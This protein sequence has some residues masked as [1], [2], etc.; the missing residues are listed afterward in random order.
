LTWS[1][2][3]LLAWAATQFAPAV[4]VPV[5]GTAAVLAASLVP[6]LTVAAVPVVASAGRQRRWLPLI[7]A[8][9]GGVRLLL[10][11]AYSGRVDPLSVVAAV[12]SQHPDVLVV[13][14]LT[15]TLAHDLTTAGLDRELAARSIQ[16]PQQQTP[17]AADA[18]IGIWSQLPVDGATR[19]PGT[20]W[21]AVT[22]TVHPPGTVPFTLVAGHVAP[23]GTAGAT[24]WNADLDALRA[25]CA[26]APGDVVLLGTLNATPW[27][28]Q[29]RDFGAAGLTDAAEFLGRGLRPT[30]PTWSLVPLLPLDQALVSS[31]VR[32]AALTTLLISGSDHRA[33]LVTVQPPPA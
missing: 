18:G 11:S 2:V 15:T 26:A 24:A 29:L 12:R 10:V 9:A 23:P 13:T 6:L 33:L 4:T 30:W 20:R 32:V 3:V 21:P 5:V 17:D 8:A 25:A 1:A 22:A 27:H 19:I 28:R 31:R 7:A 16:L 14:E